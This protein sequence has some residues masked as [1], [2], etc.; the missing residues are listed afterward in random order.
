MLTQKYI[1]GE[2]VRVTETLPFSLVGGL[3]RIIPGP[4]R[5]LI[6]EGDQNV[7]RLVLTALS[8]F[9]ILRCPGNLKLETITKPFTGLSEELPSYE[10]SRVLRSMFGRPSSLSD[11]DQP[12]H[13]F[14]NKAGPNSSV[15]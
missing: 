15:S 11:L 1:S 4:F 13:L 8:L 14:I 9:R 10:L 2:K 7:I 5:K 3:P 6:R 12:T